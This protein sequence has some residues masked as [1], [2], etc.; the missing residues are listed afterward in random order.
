MN[1]E[2]VHLEFLGDDG[3]AVE[4]GEYGRTVI[5]NLEDEA[6]PLIR[7]ENNDRGGWLVDPCAC[8]RTLPCIDSVK[9][10]E[11]ESF[12]LPSGKVVSG[13]YLTTLFDARPD[14]VRGF[15][16]VQHRDASITVEYV[17]AKGRDEGERRM[18][19]AL[20]GLVRVVG[21]EVPVAFKPVREIPHD[22]GKLRFVVR[23]K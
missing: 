2:H 8:G 5:T 1:V 11:S 14:L 20:S 23:E 6:F 10:R 7:Y 13:E 4:R 9:G 19:E 18:A 16:V 22:R 21:G 17:P 15:R 3:R 12:V